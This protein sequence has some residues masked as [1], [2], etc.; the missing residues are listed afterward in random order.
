M[1]GDILSLS[2]AIVAMVAMAVA[3]WFLVFCCGQF[4]C[5]RCGAKVMWFPVK[6]EGQETFH[7]IRCGDPWEA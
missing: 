5:R 4:R 1:S 6:P 7:C 3:V 2:F